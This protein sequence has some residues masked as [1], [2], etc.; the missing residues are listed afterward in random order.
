[1]ELEDN[2]QEISTSIENI[3]VYTLKFAS[4]QVLTAQHYYG[5]EYKGV[6]RKLGSGGLI[7]K[8]A[9]RKKVIMHKIMYIFKL[10]LN[11][12]TV[13]IKAYVASGNKFLYACVSEVCRL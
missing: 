6:I 5:T 8:Q 11:I 2:C 10:L 13:G 7:T 3:N 4:D 1:M 9:M 12:V